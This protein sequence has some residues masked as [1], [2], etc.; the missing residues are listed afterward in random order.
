MHHRHHACDQERG[1][2]ADRATNPTAWKPCRAKGNRLD[3]LANGGWSAT[4]G[5]AETK[6]P[7]GLR[8]HA[9][10]KQSFQTTVGPYGSNSAT[11]V[12]YTFDRSG[13]FQLGSGGVEV[14]SFLTNP[15]TLAFIS[16]NGTM[17][18]R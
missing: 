16:I 14:A 6:L 2:A 12:T 4:S 17:F 10:S 15:K 3:K 11:W 18:N 5:S 8:S 13:R 1:V 7:R 9:Y